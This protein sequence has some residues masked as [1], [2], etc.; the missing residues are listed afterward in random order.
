[1]SQFKQFL[2]ANLPWLHAENV[3]VRAAETTFFESIGEFD[4]KVGNSDWMAF[5]E[6]HRL[7]TENNKA[8][9]EQA[10][11]D[12]RL[13]LLTAYIRSERFCDGTIRSK[14]ADGEL[15]LL[16]QSFLEFN[17]SNFPEEFDFTQDD[18]V[19]AKQRRKGINPMRQE[20][21][22]HANGRRMSMGI[23]PFMP[24]EK[25]PEAHKM[26]MAD[27]EFVSSSEFVDF[28]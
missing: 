2:Q 8:F 15:P 11:I 23:K 27:A 25:S 3:D 28:S 5:L 17:D 20:Y 9:I 12:Q 26:A 1:M 19:A 24:T 14:I 21:I 7:T 22:D 10:D 6:S 4:F 18:N 13:S 16:L